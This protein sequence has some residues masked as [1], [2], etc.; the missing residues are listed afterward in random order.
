[1]LDEKN[2]SVETFDPWVDSNEPPTNE[3]SIFFIGTNHDVFLSY[4]F[5]SGSIVID[6]WRF[7]TEQDGVELIKI[8]IS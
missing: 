6:P 2:V 4:K 8:G 5:P 1:M 7:M 3:K